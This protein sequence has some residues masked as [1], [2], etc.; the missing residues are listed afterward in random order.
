MFYRGNLVFLVY[1]D[2]GIFFSLDGTSIDNLIKELQYS[3]LKLE[4]Q[5]HPADCVG[6]NI[7]KQGDGSYEFMQPALT[8]QIIEDVRLGP[9]T[10]P[11]PIPV[12]DQRLLHRHLDSPPHN[13][14]KFQ[15]RSVI[16]KL[17]YL[18]QC[19]R[20]DIVY[21][22]HQCARFSSNARKDHTDTVEYISCYLKGTSDL[23]LSFKPDISKSF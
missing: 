6:V 5:G 4:D 23:V 9:R 19:I 17:N 7:K 2:D 3:K 1:I 16:G 11:K 18:A 12:C 8:H 22:V 15:Y 20:P 13:K 21:A 14:S 10:T